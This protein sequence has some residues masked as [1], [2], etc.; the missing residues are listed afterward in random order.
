LKKIKLIMMALLS[1]MFVGGGINHFL[2][3]EFYMRLMPPYLPFHE[4][5]I[6]LSGVL[7]I[8]V[9]VG[10]WIKKYRAISAWGMIGIMIA[11]F[12]ANVHAYLNPQEFPEV[13]ELTLLLRLP[14]QGL[15]ILWAWWYTRKPAT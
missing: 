1:L 2:N 6:W 9:G 5:L 13:P 3:L 14:M 15:F 11:V 10:I 4:Q 8:I 7:E 12:P